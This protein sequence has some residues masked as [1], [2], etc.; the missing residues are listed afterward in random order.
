MPLGASRI[1]LLAKS[2]IV[3]VAE[4]IRRK[5]GVSAFGNAQ[6]D[7]AQSKFG[8]A[9]ALF[10]GS[11]DYLIANSIDLSSYAT[12]DWTVEG[13]IRINSL[14]TLQNV[15][16]VGYATNTFALCRLLVADDGDLNIL[17]SNAST[18]NQLVSLETTNQPITTNTWYH[19]AAVRN[20]SNFN[21][22]LNGTSVASATNSGSVYTGSNL[23]SLGARL[24]SGSFGLFQNGWTDEFR[25]SNTA[26]YTANFTA[27]TAAFVNDESTLLLLHMDGTDS[28]TFFEDDNGIRSQTG[29][30]ATGGAIIST[31][32]SKFGGSSWNGS[33]SSTA[34]MLLPQTPYTFGTDDFT[35]EC[36][37]NVDLDFSSTGSSIFSMGTSV[38][39]ASNY[40]LRIGAGTNNFGLTLGST[41]YET[42]FIWSLDVW[43]H[44]AVVRSNGVVSLYI[45]GVKD[46]SIGSSGN[47][48]FTTSLEERFLGIGR[49]TYAGVRAFPGYIDEFRVSDTARYTADFT[50]PTA[51]FVN[52][53][54]T[55]LLLHMDGT[56]AST[57]FEDDNGVRAQVGISAVG[58]AQVDTA[59]SKFGGASLLLDGTGD[60]LNIPTVAT[61]FGTNDFTAEAWFRFDGSSGAFEPIIDTRTEAGASGFFLGL[62]GSLRPVYFVNSAARITG[63]A[64][65][66]NT[67]YHL[68]LVKESGVSKLYIDGTQVGSNFSD[69]FNFTNSLARIGGNYLS[70][71]FWNGNID[72]VRVSNTARYTG[73]FTPATQPFQNDANTLLLLHMDGT[74]AST[75]FRDD[76]GVTPDYEY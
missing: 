73:N 38:N 53:A 57:V 36:W 65:S 60:Y 59:Q 29:L 70:T 31:T 37:A 71:G 12:S 18:T 42:T 30:T 40:R 32:R 52:D 16:S 48:T 66:A 45:N 35:I 39:D 34:T 67:W 3:A 49:I 17:C 46:T 2:Q 23:T 8:G 72:E 10:D 44:L 6:V 11:G 21:L 19:V 56:D 51:P 61:N 28:Q 68:A 43:Y 62:D 4:V 63:T 9:S 75:V 7:T 55:L 26:R 74:D 33:S 47:I 24:S 50:A 76:N 1:T 14:A 13:W 25:V 54:N 20:G 58:N 69:S 5:V 41:A 27:P 64:I 22:Y 15:W